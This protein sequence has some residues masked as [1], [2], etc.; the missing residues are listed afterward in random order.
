MRGEITREEAVESTI[1]ETRQYTSGNYSFRRDPEMQWLR[2]FGDQAE[3]R[4][5]AAEAI[6]GKPA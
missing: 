5:Q 4:E 1:I 3:V 6:G 2:G